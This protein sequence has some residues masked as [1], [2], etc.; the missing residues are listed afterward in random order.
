MTKEV[1]AQVL[2]QQNHPRSKFSNIYFFHNKAREE[3]VL[4][5]LFLLENSQ[6]I[7]IKG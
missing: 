4:G 1:N 6:L 5:P 2:L 7:L 3:G